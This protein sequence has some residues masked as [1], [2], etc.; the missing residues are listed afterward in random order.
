MTT[1]LLAV[2]EAEMS[3]PHGVGLHPGTVEW[4]G[5]AYGTEC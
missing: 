3:S 5:A 2:L 4:A 1:Y